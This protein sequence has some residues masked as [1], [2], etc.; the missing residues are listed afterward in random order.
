MLLLVVLI[1]ILTIYCIVNL[2]YALLLTFLCPLLLTLVLMVLLISLP[3]LI[4]TWL[5]I[6][7]S[8]LLLIVSWFVPLL[9]LITC[10]IYFPIHGT[11]YCMIRFTINFPTKLYHEVYHSL[12]THSND[13]DEEGRR[14]RWRRQ[15]RGRRGQKTKE[16]ASS[17]LLQSTS[18][19]S[20]PQLSK[21]GGNCC[22]KPRP[23]QA[24][25]SNH[26]KP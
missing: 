10:C 21:C 26:R 1:I 7:S 16:A 2:G 15:P 13:N 24:D 6:S 20:N 19:C 17:R 12:A 18:H 14:R 5:V 8:V 25:K 9:L 23:S 3:T 22:S 4:L 11:S